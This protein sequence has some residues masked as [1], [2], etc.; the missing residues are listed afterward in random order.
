MP[1][2]TLIASE[3]SVFTAHQATSLAVWPGKS[4]HRWAGHID[5]SLQSLVGLPM[6]APTRASLRALWRSPSN[7]VSTE[8][9]VLATVAWGG[10]KANHGRDFWT[11]KASWLPLC[12]DIRS[13]AHTRRSAFAAFS[14]L[15]TAGQLPSMGP[16]YFT[17]I[18]FFAAPKADGYILDQWTA[19][20]VHILT[21]QWAWPAV[22]IDHGT[23]LKASSN[24]IHLRVRVVDRVTSVDY[25]DFC[26]L[27]D[28]IGFRL[29][30]TPERA[31]E[32]L[33]SSGGKSP[34]PWRG[35]VMTSWATQTPP[36]Y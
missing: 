21:G 31:E 32:M 1:P 17:K 23:K 16:A 30:I 29:G 25:E 13:G 18:I 9:C 8:F 20:S 19:R 2:P 24:P 36:F 27:V 10:M 28:N 7:V 34:R 3:F 33:F 6:A 22:A 15:R 5:A 11:A 12:D 14:A 26:L 35:H 4:P